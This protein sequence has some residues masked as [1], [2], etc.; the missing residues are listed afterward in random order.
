MK[1]LLLLAVLAGI[2]FALYKASEA[3]KQESSEARTVR[4]LPPSVQHVVLQMD[5]GAQSALFN[6]YESKKKRTS[7]GY[8]FWLFLGWH[9][10]YARQIGLQFAFWFTLGGFGIW[11][12]VDLFRMP[13]IIRACNEQVARQALQTLGLGTAF[14]DNPPRVP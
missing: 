14:R 10:I 2:G 8:I 9:Y 4:S 12:L 7:I 1:G 11:W 13:S 5:P 3:S 6:E